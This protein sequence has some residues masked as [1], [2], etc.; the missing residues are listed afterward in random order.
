MKPSEY[1]RYLAGQNQP[2]DVQQKLHAT[3]DHIDQ[4]ELNLKIANQ[5]YLAQ[6]SSQH[7]RLEQ[8]IIVLE[9]RVASMP[10]RVDL[11]VAMLEQRGR[12]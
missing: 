9:Q 2:F 11:E 3:A 5:L 7:E 1:L 8:R 4:I 10:T 12:R 6:D